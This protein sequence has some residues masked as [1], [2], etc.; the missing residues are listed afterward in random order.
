[1]I[2][3]PNEAEQWRINEGKKTEALA[4]KIF[5]EGTQINHEQEFNDT[6][7]QSKNALS[8]AQFNTPIFNAIINKENLT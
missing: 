6:L 5:P 4:H 2:S 7:I 3:P 1:M 8:C